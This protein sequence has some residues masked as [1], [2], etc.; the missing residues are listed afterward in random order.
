MLAL[1]ATLFMAVSCVYFCSAFV[2]IGGTYLALYDSWFT[3][4]VLYSFV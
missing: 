2:V 1:L 3:H 4:F